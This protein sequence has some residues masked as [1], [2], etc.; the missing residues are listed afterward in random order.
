MEYCCRGDLLNRI[1]VSPMTKSVSGFGSKVL[2][3]VDGVGLFSPTI[4]KRHTHTRARIDDKAYTE[5]ET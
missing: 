3:E 1:K 4:A 5:V 2:Q